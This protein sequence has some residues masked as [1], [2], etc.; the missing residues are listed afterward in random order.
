MK[1]S[2][3]LSGRQGLNT[4]LQRVSR[5]FSRL[6][7]ILNGFRGCRRVVKYL[8]HNKMHAQLTHAPKVKIFA[9]NSHENTRRD[10]HSILE[11]STQNFKR[12]FHNR[13]YLVNS[14]K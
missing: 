13:K 4:R 10:P 1:F 11:Q 5:D 8:L 14:K 9:W 3:K 7:R 12:N 2:L 6:Q